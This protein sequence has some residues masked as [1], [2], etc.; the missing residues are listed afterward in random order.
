[1]GSRFVIHE[2]KTS[3]LNKKIFIKI[4]IKQKK[5]NMFLARG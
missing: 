2:Q 4:Y 1:M 3:F 5:S